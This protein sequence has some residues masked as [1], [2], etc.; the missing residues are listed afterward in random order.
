MEF[1]SF[2][3]NLPKFTKWYLFSVLLTAALSS[4]KILSPFYF[5]LIFEN[6]LFNF[7]L[8]RL[9]TTYIYVGNFGFPFIMRLV[10]IYFGFSKLEKLYKQ[11]P[12]D[13]FWLLFVVGILN[14]LISLIFDEYYL[15]SRQWAF[16][17]LYIWCKKE[18][19]ERVSFLFGLVVKSAYLP[20]AIIAYSILTGDGVYKELIG[21]AAGHA[22]IFVKD[23]L[24]NN[25]KYRLDLFRTPKFVE[26]LVWKYY[27]RPP[28]N[29]FGGQQP[30]EPQNQGPRLFGGRG[31]R[32]N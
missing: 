16:S 27:P 13:F 9:I 15:L 7:Q 17:I 28:T 22:F 32:L 3:E 29:N 19:F 31:V 20:W 8:W 18:P 24:P 5:V 12:A 23:L 2:L 21:I 1:D 30:Q 6:G 14:L 25:P 4:F 26:K 10:F 11:R